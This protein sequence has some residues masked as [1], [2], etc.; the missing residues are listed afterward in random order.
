[1]RFTSQKP[2][3]VQFH[4]MKIGATPDKLVAI[5]RATDKQAALAAVIARHRMPW[6]LQQR[7]I[8]LRTT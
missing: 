4:V 5:V 6:H 3:L 7:L 2:E 8:V 1:L